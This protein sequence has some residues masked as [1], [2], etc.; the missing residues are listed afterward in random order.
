MGTKIL[1][2]HK[3]VIT[4]GASGIGLTIAEEFLAK[5]AQVFVCDIAEAALEKLFSDSTGL[6]L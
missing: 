4:A 3:V 6:V 1:N 2:T 5:G